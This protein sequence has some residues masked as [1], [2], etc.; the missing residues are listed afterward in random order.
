MTWFRRDKGI[1][2]IEG[3]GGEMAVQ[4]EAAERVVDFL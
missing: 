1:R 3:F 2:W 4:S